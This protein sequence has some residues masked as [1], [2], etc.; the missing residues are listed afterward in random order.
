MIESY[1]FQKSADFV[2]DQGV[3]AQLAQVHEYSKVQ[4]CLIHNDLHFNSVMVKDHKPKV[5]VILTTA[6]N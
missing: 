5:S 6:W 4:E 2:A 1:F 3:R